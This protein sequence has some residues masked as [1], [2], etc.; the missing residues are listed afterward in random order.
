MTAFLALTARQ[1]QPVQAKTNPETTLQQTG[2]GSSGAAM[3]IT[4]TMPMYEAD[5]RQIGMVMMHAI[6][7]LDVLENLQQTQLIERNQM[8]GIGS[9]AGMT[10]TADMDTMSMT[11]SQ[12]PVIGASLEMLGHA[13]ESVGQMHM[14]MATLPALPLHASDTGPTGVGMADTMMTDWED[15]RRIADILNGMVDATGAQVGV[16]DITG[17]D[18]GATGTTTST[19]GTDTAGTDTGAMSSRWMFDSAP[20]IPAA[21]HTVMVMRDQLQ[22]M[23]ISVNAL[24]GAEETGTTDTSATDTT[25]DTIGTDTTTATD[26]MMAMPMTGVG[27]AFQMMGHSLELMGHMHKMIYMQSVL[28]NSV[29]MAGAGTGTMDMEDMS[30]MAGQIDELA[31]AINDHLTNMMGNLGMTP[32]M[33]D[34]A[35]T[36]GTETAASDTTTDTT[37]TGAGDTTAGMNTDPLMAGAEGT[38]TM[39]GSAAQLIQAL[40]QQVQALNSGLTEA[41]AQ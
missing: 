7:A 1:V 27:P 10:D 29:G 34:A 8:L 16:M 3:S 30:Q 12:A 33:A 22:A 5:I 25:T 36:T 14:V 35:D 20:L 40:V 21:G 4:G 39:L 13:L 31:Q 6:M 15:A 9:T 38:R 28:N 24:T 37:G 2:T 18:T 23:M 11:G 19:A 32:M 41:S 17:T 26:P